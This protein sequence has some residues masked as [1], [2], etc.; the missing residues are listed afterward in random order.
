M[1]N[2][3]V[4]TVYLFS[5]EYNHSSSSYSLPEVLYVIEAVVNGVISFLVKIDNSL[6]SLMCLLRCVTIES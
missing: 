6:S 3:G 5:A 1:F 4:C 2:E